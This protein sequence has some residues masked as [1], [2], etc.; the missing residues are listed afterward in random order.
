VRE[1]AVQYGIEAVSADD[2]FA[3]SEL[4]YLESL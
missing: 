1:S 4:V 2:L 3:D